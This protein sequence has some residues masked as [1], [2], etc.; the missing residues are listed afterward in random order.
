MVMEFHYAFDLVGVYSYDFVVRKILFYDAEFCLGGIVCL[1]CRVC[2]LRVS[3]L[4][5]I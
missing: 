4:K 2:S 5:K 1:D 3:G